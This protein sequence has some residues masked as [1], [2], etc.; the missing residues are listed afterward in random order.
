M[1]KATIILYEKTYI[2]T[3]LLQLKG[4]GVLVMIT[5]KLISYKLTVF[6]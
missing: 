6:I 5:V 3:Y 4:Y 1:R 2:A